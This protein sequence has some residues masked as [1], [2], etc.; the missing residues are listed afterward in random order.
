MPRFTSLLSS[1]VVHLTVVMFMIWSTG[2][3]RDAE[4]QH[5]KKQEDSKNLLA[6]AARLLFPE[7]SSPSPEQKPS[8]KPAEVQTTETPESAQPEPLPQPEFK[9]APEP[10]PV[11]QKSELSQTPPAVPTRETEESQSATEPMAPIEYSG[12]PVTGDSEKLD[13][14]LD[15]LE[16]LKGHD[17]TLHVEAPF[18]Q[19]SGQL[20][21]NGQKAP[22]LTVGFGPNVIDELLKTGDV[23]LFCNIVANSKLQLRGTLRNPNSWGPMS[24][25]TANSMSMRNMVLPV[26]RRDTKEARQQLAKLGLTSAEVSEA[27][28]KLWFSNKLDQYLLRTQ[29]NVVRDKPETDWLKYTTHIYLELEHGQ[30]VA[31]GAIVNGNSRTQPR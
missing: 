26:H 8:P 13:P 12:S 6:A 31:R 24:G 27:E 15:A 30:I 20:K 23:A 9:P 19:Q 16:F 7:T 21:L 28:L 4:G 11:E 5:L 1:L 17:G 18:G 14:E 22:Q 3:T 29:L 25:A 2:Q 10:Q